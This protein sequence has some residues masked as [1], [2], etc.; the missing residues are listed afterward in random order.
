MIPKIIH[1]CWFGRG[2]KP[3]LALKCIETWKKFCPDYKF[4]EWNEDNFDIENNRYVREAYQ[5]RKWAFVTDYVRLWALYNYG[6]VYMDTDV[7]VIKPLDPYLK[8]QAF[9]GFE[10]DTQIP[11]GI[12]ACEKSFGLF[13]ELLDYYD[14]A[15]FIMPDGSLNLTTNVVTITN[16]MSLHGF[17][18]NNQYQVLD[19]Y[20]FYPNN[21][22]CPDL[23]RLG[24]KKYMAD[25]VTIH[26][27]AGSWKSQAAI[28]RESSLWWRALI[29]PLSKISRLVEQA[30]GEKYS[31]LKDKFWTRRL[32]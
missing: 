19:G 16:Q 13:K 17:K 18:P 3:E 15:S 10:N 11:T 6:G 8:H 7:E 5:S 14:D 25:T 21:I 30:G 28:K 12:M 4:V 2:Q 32:K 31:E 29:V 27:F 22:F 26:H 1:Y 24:D 9:S 20:A 23:N